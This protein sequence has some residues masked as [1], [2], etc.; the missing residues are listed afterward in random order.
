M[1]LRKNNYRQSQLQKI[2]TENMKIFYNLLRIKSSLSKQ[3]MNK[4]NLV[5]N[6]MKEMLAQFD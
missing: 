5:N 4:H 6:N 1:A 2:D 3:S